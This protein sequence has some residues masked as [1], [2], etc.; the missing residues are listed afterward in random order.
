MH[1][2]GAKGSADV[3]QF[4]SE[5]LQGLGLSGQ[6]VVHPLESVLRR[7]QQVLII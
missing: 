1:A 2:L 6:F 3:L 7:A 5:L 4:P